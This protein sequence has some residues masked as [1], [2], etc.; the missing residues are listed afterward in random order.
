MVAIVAFGYKPRRTYVANA[1]DYFTRY[2][3]L[4]DYRRLGVD[5]HL[6]AIS[7]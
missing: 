3:L 1:R 2:F 4:F 7:I 6:N 5:E